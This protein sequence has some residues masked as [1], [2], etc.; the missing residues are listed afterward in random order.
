MQRR[1]REHVAH[2]G[3]NQ[4]DQ[5]AQGQGGAGNLLDHCGFT[6]APRLPDQHRG[7]RAQ[8]DHQR[9]K[10]KHNGK[11]AR[12]RR[13]RLRTQHLP[14]VNAIQRAGDVLQKVE[15]HHRR[16]KDQV[17][18]PQRPLRRFLHNLNTSKQS[19]EGLYRTWIQKGYQ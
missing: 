13:Q 14:D 15:Q 6:G 8:A 18:L 16:Q 9:D 12:H 2:Q 19:S 10:E 17:D 7:T 11:H 5:Q 4:P 3:G 1:T